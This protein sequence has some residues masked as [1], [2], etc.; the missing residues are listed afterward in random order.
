MSMMVYKQKVSWQCWNLAYL[1]ACNKAWINITEEQILAL[2]HFLTHT[3]AKNLLEPFWVKV[4]ECMTE[5]IARNYL[6]KWFYLVSYIRV[7]DFSK[8]A[9][10][11]YILDFNWW[12]VHFFVI[13]EYNPETWLYRCQNSWWD[14]WWDWWDF[15]FHESNWKKLYDTQRV[16][17]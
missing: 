3:R 13:K 2:P 1:L 9:K 16:Y 12:S 8:A 11:P 7:W 6:K 15:Y 17:A 14:K 5:T 10:K 4:A